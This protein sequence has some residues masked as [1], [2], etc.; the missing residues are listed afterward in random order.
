MQTPHNPYKWI[1]L[2]IDNYVREFYGKFLLSAVAAERGWGTILAYKNDIRKGLPNIDGVVIEP[3]MMKQKRVDHYHGNNW[4]FCAFDEEGLIYYSP[5]EYARRR[6]CDKEILNKLDLLFLWGNNQRKDILD[7]VENI[8][9]RLR[10]TGNPRIDMVRPDLREFNSPDVS[11]IRNNYGRYILINTN[12]GYVNNLLG[13]DYTLRN[14]INT[15]RINNEEQEWDQIAREKHQALIMQA[16]IEMLPWLSEQFPDRKIIIRPHPSENFETWRLAARGLPNVIVIHEGDSVPWILGADVVIHNNCTTGVQAHLL[17]KPVIAYMPVR[18]DNHDLYLPK[19]VSYQAQDVDHLINLIQ[20]FISN[21]SAIHNNLNQEQRIV[22]KEY[23]EG[24][25]GPWTSDRIIDELE[26][27]DINPQVLDYDDISGKNEG[28]SQPQ[29][30]NKI[31]TKLK[32]LLKYRLIGMN[33]NTAIQR[34]YPWINPTYDL[35]KFPILSFNNLQSYLNRLQETTGRFS[36]VQVCLT[37]NNRV[38]I[39]PAEE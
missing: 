25:E 17:G 28:V 30:T 7:H 39:F 29:D 32:N 1:V 2:P 15:K 22:V 31:L 4:R 34:E 9:T 23:I 18:S 12:F 37:R 35:Q 26:K 19:A 13:K 8:E 6:L 16:F 3:S 24:L 5:E 11:L 14:L 10:L 21:P 27:L 36:N 38:C 33:P 20:E